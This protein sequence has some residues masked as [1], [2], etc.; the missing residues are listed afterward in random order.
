M[1]KASK[2]ITVARESEREKERETNR[3]NKVTERENHIQSN[4]QMVA[5]TSEAKL[6]PRRGVVPARWDDPMGN[7]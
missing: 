5:S 1:K 4:G 3:D 6:T 2:I 7:H